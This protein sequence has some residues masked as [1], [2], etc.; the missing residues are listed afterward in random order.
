MHKKH[1]KTKETESNQQRGS[2][3]QVQLVVDDKIYSQNQQDKH[4][5]P[6][7]LYIYIYMFDTID[8]DNYNYIKHNSTSISIIA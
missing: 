8:T 6:F 2:R 3:I 7:M 5:A 1:N 4:K